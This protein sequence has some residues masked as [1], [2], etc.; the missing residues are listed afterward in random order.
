MQLAP[1][2]YNLH[3]LLA[4]PIESWTSHLPRIRAMGFDWLYVNSFAAPGASGSIYAVADPFELHPLVRGSAGGWAQKLIRDFASRAAAAGL[5]VMTD[6]ILPHAARD[7]RLVA[8]RPDWF[9]WHPGG[10]PTAPMLANPNDP[11]RPRYMEDLAELDLASPAKRAAQLDWFQHVA[12][13]YLDAGVSGF[14]CS[15]AY[16]VPP[17]LWRSLIPSLRAEHSDAVFLAAAL[18]CPFER[19][20]AL[21]DCGFDLIF[22]SSRWWNFHDSWFLDQYEVLRRI[23]PTVSFPEDHN[24][25]RLAVDAGVADPEAIAQLY[26]ARYLACASP[27]SPPW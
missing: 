2:I 11:L 12:R 18:G 25:Q 16:K 24:T 8:E 23:A 19:T 22:D 17:D 26:R 7:G 21:A 10:G 4:G 15:A 14:R 6:L 20:R 3:P 27:M 9:R 13:H 1:R 5:K